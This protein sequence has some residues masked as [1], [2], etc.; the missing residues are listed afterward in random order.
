MSGLVEWRC[1]AHGAYGFG[2][3][4]CPLCVCE[5]RAATV[6]GPAEPVMLGWEGAHIAEQVV[7]DRAL[8]DEEDAAVSA[9]WRRRFPYV[10]F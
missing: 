1:T 8:T 6:I 5:A 10:A 9:G 7:F 2:S 4:G 3:D